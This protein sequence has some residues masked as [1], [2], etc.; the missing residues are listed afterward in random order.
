MLSL[1]RR[2]PLALEQQ[3]REEGPLTRPHPEALEGRAPLARSQSIP[4]HTIAPVPAAMRGDSDFSANESA[5]GEELC[6]SDGAGGGTA[7]RIDIRPGGAGC[8]SPGRTAPRR[9][10]P[11]PVGRDRVPRR[12]SRCYHPRTLRSGIPHGDIKMKQTV[13]S[14]IAL[15]AASI[16]VFLTP[17]AA[18]EGFEA[19]VVGPGKFQYRPA[20]CAWSFVG[21]AGISGNGSGFT[22]GNPPAPEG[23]QV[24]FLQKD[25]SFSQA[26]AGWAA[27]SY[28]LTFYA[29]QRGNNGT[30]RQ[31]F[32]VLV[33]G[34]VVGTFT[35]SGTSYQIYTTAAFSRRRRVAHH[36]LPGAQH[37]RRRQH[38][39]HRRRR[40]AG[41]SAPPVGDAG[42]EQVAV[43]AGQFQYNP[44]GSPW[45]F[46][47][48]A[49]IAANGS[50]FTAGNPPA[51]EGTQ[52][53]F[54]QKAGS[55]SQAVAGWA[56]GSYRLTFYAAQR[57]NNGTSR[58]DFQRPGRRRR[59]RHVHALRHVVPGLHHGRVH[60]SPPGRTPSR[61]RA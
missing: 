59:G 21:D 32:Q 60:A 3:P 47:G 45:A 51:P 15:L 57:G 8:P 44:T 19:P 46:A 56:A 42:F 61:S 48:D 25:G 43:G 20:G 52:V 16:G 1:P 4:A 40:R 17:P 41:Q 22:A 11:H 26:V 33:D 14:T 28:R 7:M 5:E 55:F 38:R 10:D 58:Q 53:A 35:P 30:S 49:G 31:D 23:A 18:N 39:L 9:R 54:L 34:A 6:K 36:R 37:R 29:A 12:T 13:R 27:G 50:G 24:A 2:R